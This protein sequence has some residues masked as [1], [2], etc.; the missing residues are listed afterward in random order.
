[1]STKQEKFDFTTNL[2]NFS[3]EGKTIAVPKEFFDGSNENVSNIVYDAISE[4]EDLG[5]QKIEVSVPDTKFCVATYYLNVYAEFASAMQKFDG[6]KYGYRTENDTSLNA[7]ISNNRVESFGGEVQRRILFGTFIS[8]KEFQSKWY[9][10]ALHA[11]NFIKEEY[12]KIFK[13]ADFM[14]SPASPFTAFEIGEKINDPVE[15]YLADTLVGF[16][17]LAGIPAGVL[18]YGFSKGLPVGVQFAG[19]ANKDLEV[20]Q[21]MRALEIKRGEIKWPQK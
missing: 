10:K 18:P 9:S 21:A 15:M 20:L 16:A 13:Q 1:V 7:T 5:A 6:L 4:L 19:G 3:F 2:D 17:N 8:M 14:I 12:Q 11:K